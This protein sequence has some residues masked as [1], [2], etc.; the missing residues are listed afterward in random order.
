LNAVL[1]EEFLTH[2]ASHADSVPVYTDGSKSATGVGF[3]AVFPDFT[4]RGSLSIC[5]SVFTAELYAILLALMHILRSP[6]LSFVVF[7]DSLS[8]L[9]AVEGFNTSNSLV[10]KIQ[11]WLFFISARHKVVSFCW[12][13]GHVGVVGNEKA[14]TV[15]KLASTD[16]VSLAQLP[17]S[18]FKS[19]F[20]FVF[21]QQWQAAW[22]ATAFTNKLRNV[23]HS[24]YRWTHPYSKVRRDEVIL[25]RLRI[26]HTRL[27]HGHLM[28]A[29]GVLPYC[30]SCLV[31]LTV[32]HF[33]VEC[34][35]FQAHRLTAF[36]ALPANGL[37]FTLHTMLSE[38]PHFSL[39]SILA[40]LN[41][42]GLLKSV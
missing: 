7:S 40:F 8:A 22:S 16:P 36:P 37:P 3:A 26:G 33:M 5:A 35:D 12:V 21:I 41:A 38:G 42:I 13:P 11:Q 19:Y 29:S 20:K 10:Q 27:T 9:Q 32:E 23:K 25:A 17:H 24:V 31:P 18:D 39:P 28:E 14:D 4:E 1:C 6:S 15:A 30:H 34:P 2:A